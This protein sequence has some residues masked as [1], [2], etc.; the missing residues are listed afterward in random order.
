MT[1]PISP[2]P[3]VFQ[4]PFL[5]AAPEPGTPGEDR[6]SEAGGQGGDGPKWLWISMDI[7]YRYI[8]PLCVSTVNIG[9]SIYA[10]ETVYIYIYIYISWLSKEIAILEVDVI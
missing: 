9:S 8:A 6:F 5:S 1:S 3:T 7:R 10:F 2:C 4:G